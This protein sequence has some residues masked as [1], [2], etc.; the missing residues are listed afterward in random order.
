MMENA[1]TLERPIRAY[2]TKEDEMN[3]NHHADDKNLRISAEEFKARLEAGEPATVLDARNRE[4]WQSSPV[5]VKGARRW[6]G[7]VD[8]AWPKERLTVVY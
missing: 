8:P 5:K 6:T 4:P 1:S 7:Q 3:S 2:F